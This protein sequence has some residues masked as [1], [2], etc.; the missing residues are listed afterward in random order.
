M[1]TPKRQGKDWTPPEQARLRDLA[2]GNT[3]T[4][5][6]ALKLSRT[7]P[8]V[9]AKAQQLRLSLKPVNQSPYGPRRRRS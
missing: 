8:G 1:G 3:P 5:L 9:R 7:E 2:A 4:R 6:I